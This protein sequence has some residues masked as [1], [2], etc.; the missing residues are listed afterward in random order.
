MNNSKYTRQV[1]GWDREVTSIQYL[2]VLPISKLR[3]WAKNIWEEE[4]PKKPMPKI[5]AG[6][7]IRYMNEYMSFSQKNLIV[8][9]RHQRNKL[10]LLHEMCHCFGTDREI[11]HGPTFQNRYATLLFKYML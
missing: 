2:P 6:R 4:C 3:N 7:G 10:I 5:V 1:Y 8:L 11:D 9:S